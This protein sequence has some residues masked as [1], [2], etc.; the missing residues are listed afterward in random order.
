MHGSIKSKRLLS[1]FF[2][3]LLIITATLSGCGG[4][5]GGNIPDSGDGDI[6]Q[7]EIKEEIRLAA[8]SANSVLY[9]VIDGIDYTI[10][11]AVVNLTCDFSATVSAPVIINSKQHNFF[12]SGQAKLYNGGTLIDCNY[13]FENETILI[14]SA[15]VSG[16]GNISGSELS[17]NFQGQFAITGDK[18]FLL[19][20]DIFESIDLADYFIIN[21]SGTITNTVY[22][23]HQFPNVS[24]NVSNV[25]VNVAESLDLLDR[26][27]SGEYI[28]L[29][30]IARVVKSGDVNGQS[31]DCN[32]IHVQFNGTNLVDV[33]SSCVS[34]NNFKVNV[35]TGAIVE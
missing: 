34:P 10:Q 2:I 35:D 17:S 12:A 14:N 5:G 33:S 26:V 13:F 16:S 32:D 8:L 4:G 9:Q 15:Q 21:G 28:T 1:A 27:I 20:G 23:G 31:S 7:N 11:N 24:G 3:F 30:D 19:S 6:S 18:G 29:G 25:M 22:D